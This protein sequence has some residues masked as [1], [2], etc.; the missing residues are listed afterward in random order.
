MSAPPPQ[1]SVPPPSAHPAPGSL[2]ALRPL[3]VVD[4]HDTGP[5]FAA[6]ARGQLVVRQCACGAISHLPVAYCRACGGFDASWVPVSGR[7]SVLTWTTVVHQLHPAFPTPYTLV[8]VAL[9]EHPQVHL[10]GH[11]PGTPSIAPGQAAQVWFE[12]LADGVV[13]PQWRLVDGGESAREDER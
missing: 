5:F 6:A 8:M 4:D 9:D 11:L 7:G 2:P 10:F 1:G 12:A 3:P 13:I